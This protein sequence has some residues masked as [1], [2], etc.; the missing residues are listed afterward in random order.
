MKLFTGLYPEEYRSDPWSMSVL[1]ILRVVAYVWLVYGLL[2]GLIY[3]SLQDLI[4]T[5]SVHWPGFES[6]FDQ[7]FASS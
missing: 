5:L 1:H 6:W 4:L 3:H 7:L 2:G